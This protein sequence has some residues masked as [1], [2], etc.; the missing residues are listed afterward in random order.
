MRYTPAL[1]EGFLQMH[2]SIV[3]TLTGRFDSLHVVSGRRLRRHGCLVA[4]PWRLLFVRVTREH[5]QLESIT[6]AQ[7]DDIVLEKSGCYRTLSFS[8]SGNP[9]R[10][11]CLALGPLNQPVDLD[12]YWLRQRVNEVQTRLSWHNEAAVADAPAGPPQGPHL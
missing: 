7:I 3:W 2:E 9:C 11:R 12:M 4:T 10:M 6:L 1:L 5:I 8:A